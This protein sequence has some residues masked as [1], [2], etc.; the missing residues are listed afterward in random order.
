M[1]K[2][3][4]DES[5]DPTKMNESELRDAFNQCMKKNMKTQYYSFQAKRIMPRK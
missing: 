3:Q 4:L 1:R 2:W 5:I